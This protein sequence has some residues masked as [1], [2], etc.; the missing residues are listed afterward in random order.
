MVFAEDK[1]G[2]S[3][4]DKTDHSDEDRMIEGNR[5]GKEQT[6]HA[7]PC[8]HQREKRQKDRAGVASEGVDFAGAKAE[9]GIVRMTAG[10]GVGKGVDAQRHRVGRHVDAVGK[11]SHGAIGDACDDL[12]D[13]H[14]KREHDDDPGAGFACLL[15][16]L[17]KSM[18][19]QPTG[20][21]AGVHVVRLHLR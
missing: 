12:D 5:H 2:G 10:I 16:I 15:Q 18:I 14:G 19:V 3:V 11:Q 13:H 1:N 8:H 20:K 9:F 17:P 7:F 6:L 4:N 21:I